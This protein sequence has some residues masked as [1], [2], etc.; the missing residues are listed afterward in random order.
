VEDVDPSPALSQVGTPFPVDGRKVGIVVDDDSDPSLVAD[1][2]AAAVKVNLVPLVVGPH[3]GALG[4]VTINR[5]YATARSFEYD[6]LVF[7][8]ALPPAADAS[9]GLDARAAQADG[10]PED[11]DPRIRQL[12]AEMWRH[13]KVLAAAGTPGNDAL[14]GVGVAGAGVVADDDPTAVV[15]GIV[16]LL[17]LHRVWDRFP[18]RSA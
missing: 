7:A 3:G 9:P 1:L 10:S 15:D 5:T 18:T 12:I 13:C 6:A 2:V 8:G 14:A 17:Q 11:V 16:E 4:E